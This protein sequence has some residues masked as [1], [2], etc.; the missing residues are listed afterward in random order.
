[1]SGRLSALASFILGLP[2]TVS[3]QA[4]SY[5][6]DDFSRLAGGRECPVVVRGNPF[7]DQGWSDDDFAAAVIAAMQGRNP[8]PTTRFTAETSREGHPAHRIILSFNAGAT[9]TAAEL[10]AASKGHRSEPI[11]P[12]GKLHVI[13]AW[14]RNGAVAS[15][16]SGWIA[17]VTA[18]TDRRFARLIAQVTRDL[19]PTATEPGGLKGH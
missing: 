16:C 6:P 12:N 2:R 18:P 4:P 8:G 9:V 13:A 5:S 15:E 14:C 1:M 7:A 11:G 10:C 3:S 19:F 17:G